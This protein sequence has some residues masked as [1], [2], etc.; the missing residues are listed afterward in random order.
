[1]TF[2]N[3]VNLEG[4]DLKEAAE[5][6]VS[7]AKIIEGMFARHM[8]LTPSQVQ[9]IAATNGH[10]WLVTSIR[11]A[12]TDLTNSGKLR[13]SDMKVRGPYGKPEHLWRAA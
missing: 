8:V 3:T 4:G 7:Q 1:M 11:R 2:Y 9:I 10:R 5:Q 6:N 13:K 12:I